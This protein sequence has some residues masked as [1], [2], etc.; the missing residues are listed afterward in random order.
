MSWQDQL[1]RSADE[2]L[3][4]G[5]ELQQRNRDRSDIDQRR[6]DSFQ[7]ELTAY[8]QMLMERGG[9]TPEEADAIMQSEGFRSLLF[10][11]QQADESF[12]TQDEEGEVR[13]NPW[14]AK[15]AY[16]TEGLYGVLGAG[17][18]NQRGAFGADTAGADAAL[19]RMG[20]G[21]RDAI[22]RGEIG[23]DPEFGGRLR[24]TLGRGRGEVVDP[25]TGAR[26]EA[27]EGFRE[28]GDEVGISDRYRDAMTVGDEE[29]QGIRNVAADRVRAGNE[30]MLQNVKRR[31]AEGG[32]VNAL[33]VGALEQEARQ[34][35]EQ[36]AAEAALNAEI[37]A[38]RYRRDSEEMLEG[39]RMA[40]KMAGANLEAQGL[41]SSVGLARD[42]SDAQRGLLGAELGV[43]E[44]VEDRRYRGAAGMMDAEM[45]AAGATGAAGLAEA[46]RRRSERGAMESELAN[47][48]LGVADQDLMRRVELERQGEAAQQGR[49]AG[50]AENRQQTRQGNID[51]RYQQNYGVYN[52]MGN[53]AGQ[54]ADQ[55]IAGR[56][57]GGQILAGQ[58]QQSN[59]NAQAGY[60]R[61]VQTYGQQSGNYNN[62][63]GNWAQARNQSGFWGRLAGAAVGAATNAGMSAATGGASTL[64]QAAANA[65][66]NN[67]GFAN[68]FNQRFGWSMT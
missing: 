50:L 60:D 54:V 38:R 58:Q 7:D 65:R 14:A 67:Q 15:N 29:V 57:Q 61:G 41:A 33:A 4:R 8:R 9:Y 27:R 34:A 2:I 20:R 31:A 28:L 22:D 6:A 68:N 3:R 44:G 48:E 53:A 37:A 11:N 40:G 51:R 17:I 12:L 66:R 62:A 36:D 64:G 5:D 52:R 30:R 19:D 49:A 18:G 55:R 46:Q 47:R 23:V 42:I 10:G 26:V 39:R 59:T 16:D 24:G 13:G 63:M 25:L 56:N 43:E 35:T 1:R 32:N 21:F 45:T